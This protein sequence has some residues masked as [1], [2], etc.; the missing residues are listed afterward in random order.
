MTLL[1]GKEDRLNDREQIRSSVFSKTST[2]AIS[3]NS[4]QQ[5]QQPDVFMENGGDEKR[6]LSK[7]DSL[8][9]CSSSTKQRHTVVT[10]DIKIIH[11]G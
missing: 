10:G 4:S 11:H 3:L 8:T 5:Q 6:D 1:Y 2:S 7:M 9:D